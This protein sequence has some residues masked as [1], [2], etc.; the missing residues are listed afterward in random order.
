MSFLEQ[1]LWVLVLVGPYQLARFP[2]ELVK[3]HH[4]VACPA[5]L[6]RA[7]NLQ[8]SIWL[9]DSVDTGRTAE[10]HD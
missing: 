5:V 2:I 7:L 9:D 1:G 8:E 10:L 3:D 6:R 4:S